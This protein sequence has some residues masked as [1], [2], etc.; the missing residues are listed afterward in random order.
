MPA[1]IPTCLTCVYCDR[2]KVSCPAYPNSI[3]YEELIKDPTELTHC[4]GKYHYVYK[5]ITDHSEPLK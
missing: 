3:P 5:S 2:E 4:N 1:F